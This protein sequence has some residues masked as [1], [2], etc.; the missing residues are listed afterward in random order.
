MKTA[1]DIRNEMSDLHAK[2]QAL[3]ELAKDETRDFTDEET[4]QFDEWQAAYESLETEDLP[5]AEKFEARV[6]QRAKPIQVA[7]LNAPKAPARV[8]A[9]GKLKSFADPESA[10][11]SGR[12]IAANLYGHESSRQWC[13]DHGIRSAL[14]G[15]NI[16]KGGILVPEQFEQSIIDLREQ[17]G[18]FRRKARVA[19]M[20]GNTLEVPRRS[21]GVTAYF[22]GENEEV[23]ESDKAWD[24]ASLTARK[25]GV[26]CRYSSEISEDS[27]IS[28]ADDIAGEI[29]YAFA[30]K[31]DACGFLG[32][33]ANTTYG[34]IAGLITQCA[35]ATATVVTAAT[36]N[37]AFSTFDLA[38]F[39][40]MVG[41]LP[42]Y[43]GIRPEW[44]ISQA[45][46]AASMMRLMDAAGGNTTAQ[47]AGGVGKEFLGY[48]VNIVQTMNSTLTAQTST[49]GIAYF[50]DLSLAATLGNRR[51]IALKSSEDRYLEYDQM[52]ILGTE[53]F[54]IVV[55]D[56]GDTSN[57]GAM[58]M[59]A[60]PAS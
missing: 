40:A 32:T 31:E 50:G 54:D 22:V 16:S 14:S 11:A 21:S 28:L 8:R 47:L 4:A 12:W 33:G 19:N 48:P 55:H 34:G 1:E 24:S 20:T 18:V 56:V 42:M 29:A 36:G 7:P 15:D 6:A 51:G 52:A 30:V 53:R 13:D 39:E 43:P 35:A 49:N 2:C 27:F 44:Y 59:L 26:L 37:T 41:K 57:P 3:I 23:T 46:F 45:G 38:D 60:T 9:T 58:I 5:R 10:Y 17:Y 25:L